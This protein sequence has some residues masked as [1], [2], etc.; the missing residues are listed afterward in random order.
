MSKRIPAFVLKDCTIAAG[1]AGNRV[2]QASE[3]TI[4]VLEKT[5]ESFRN[6][7]MVKPREVA[8]GYEV[9][10]CQISESAFD[11]EMIKLFGLGAASRLIAYGYM[12]DEDG[13]EHAARFEMVADVKQIDPGSWSPAS[14]SSTGYDTTVHEGKLFIDDEEII[15]FTDTSFSVAG[16]EQR[17]GRRGALRL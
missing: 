6:A 9:T 3:I 2:G 17:P 8:M 7:G 15:A 10:T 5:M 12:E 13:T 1:E 11:P 14:K 16:Q 4:P